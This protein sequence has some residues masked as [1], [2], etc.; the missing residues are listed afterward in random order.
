[1]PSAY[2][3]VATLLAMTI[4][5]HTFNF[6]KALHCVLQDTEQSQNVK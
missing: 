2:R 6:D 5:K 3:F 4:F 1:M